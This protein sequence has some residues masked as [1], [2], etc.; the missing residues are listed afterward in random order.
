MGLIDFIELFEKA[1]EE[2][3]KQLR[4]IKDSTAPLT[5]A[6]STKAQ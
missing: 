6:A 5:P 2:T 3:K 1:S 4:K